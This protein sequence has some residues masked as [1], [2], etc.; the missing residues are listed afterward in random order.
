MSPQRPVRR[1]SSSLDDVLAHLGRPTVEAHRVIEAQWRS[2]VGSRLSGCCRPV[3]MTD[4]ELTVEA[5]DPVV[6]EEVNLMARDLARSINRLVGND[7]VASVR[8]RVSSGGGSVGAPGERA[9][10]STDGS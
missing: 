4:R 1:L 10:G 2:I 8:V 6:A 3:G 5:A 7:V 9:P